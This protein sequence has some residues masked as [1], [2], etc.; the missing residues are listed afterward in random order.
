MSGKSNSHQ[1]KNLQ[2][3]KQSLDRKNMAEQKTTTTLSKSLAK[4]WDAQ[5]NGISASAV[6][7]LSR[8]Q[9]WWICPEGHSYQRVIHS[10]SHKN[11]SC[12]VCES[13]GYLFPNL[14]KQWHPKNP[15]TFYEFRPGSG[16]KVW[17]LCEKGHEWE[18]VINSRRKHGCPYCSGLKTLPESSFAQKRPDLAKFWDYDKNT[19]NPEQVS[20][21]TNKRF[22]FVCREGHSFSSKL[23]NISNGKWCPY[24]AGKKVGYGNSLGDRDP[25]LS[26][27]WHPTKNAKTPLDYMPYSNKKVW[28]RC[29]KGHEW[30]AA[31]S[32]R[33]NGSG[34]RFCANREVGYGNSLQELFP[35]IASEIDQE[36]SPTDP[37]QIYARTSKTLWWKC[38]KGHSWEAPVS[39]RTVEKR[40]CQRCSAQTSAPEIRLAC[41]L[42]SYIPSA[43]P[44]AKIF[45]HEVDV[46]LP[47][48]LI[49]IEYDGAYYHRKRVRTFKTTNGKS[50]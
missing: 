37:L 29:S 17:W 21:S 30:Q 4:E 13:V 31:I 3:E 20:F 33:S 27:E 40:G 22:H 32:S 6:N 7:P 41:E 9:A 42:R 38:L 1:C 5:K 24:C 44:R 14:A 10:R 25:T 47:D 28:W 18:S 26:L 48:A 19:V 2:K 45:G 8:K 23:S 16:K 35:D 15:K 50:S 39:R 36:K 12:T 11:L 34:C 46:Y 43:R 49:A